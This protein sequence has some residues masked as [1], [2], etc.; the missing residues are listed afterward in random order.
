MPEQL[1]VSEPR[2][3]KD[4]LALPAYRE[5]F[6]EVLGPRANQF[7]ASIV[8][9]AS[10]PGLREASPKSII[11]AAMVSATLDLPVNPTLGMAYVV[12]YKGEAQFQ[13]GYK[14][15]IQLALRSG[16]YRRMNSGPINA[17]VFTG[18]DAVGEPMLDYR[19]QDPSKPTGGYFAAFELTNGFTKVVYW[20]KAQVE[21]HA[22]RFS[23]AFQKGYKSS[24]WFSD[25]DAMATKTVIKSALTKW[26]IMSVEMQGAAVADQSVTREIGAE[27][28]YIDAPDTDN[29]DLEQAA[30]P[31]PA[32][33]AAKRAAL[34]LKAKGAAA[35]K[36]AG[37][38]STA[39]APPET[40]PTSAPA[41]NSTPA[42]ESAP[43]SAPAAETKP[44]AATNP[45][46]NELPA[47][48]ASGAAKAEEAEEADPTPPHPQPEGWPLVIEAAVLEAKEIGMTIPGAKPGEQLKA[49]TIRC[50]LGGPE[51]S[52]LQALTGA[53]NAMINPYD[54]KALEGKAKASP[55]VARFTIQSWESVKTPG[56]YVPVIMAVDDIE[57]C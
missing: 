45:S 27:P 49:K 21:A 40:K 25:F 26:G 53:T 13:I 10:L 34:P 28:E 46:E 24:P 48:G 51:A 56:T 32:E 37:G 29:P 12:A 17:E 5:R 1:A 44:P 18:Y 57:T 16:Q 54:L 15:L 7:M 33:L 3:V 38:S 4:Y 30:P 31:T 20:T 9:V 8:A 47:A 2:T 41:I 6:S 11:A 36:S 52:K 42:T 50:V 55:A 22:R 23:M 19:K 43:T 39:E 14:G 35:M